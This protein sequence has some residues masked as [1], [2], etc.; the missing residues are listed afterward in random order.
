MAAGTDMVAAERLEKWIRRAMVCLTAA[1]ERL[2]ASEWACHVMACWPKVVLQRRWTPRM[3]AGLHKVDRPLCVRAP[4][5]WYVGGSSL[6]LSG[7]AAS[8][9]EWLLPFGL[10][11]TPEPCAWDM[12]LDGRHEPA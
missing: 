5:H 7:E 12:R 1:A 8:S 10:R 2:A 3:T 4:A 11:R 9:L 6:S